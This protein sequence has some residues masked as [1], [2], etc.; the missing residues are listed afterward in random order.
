[1]A[2]VPAPPDPAATFDR[3]V[4]L[5][6]PVPCDLFFTSAPAS[7]VIDVAARDPRATTPVHGR[8]LEQVDPPVRIFRD[9]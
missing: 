8:A 4:A 5:C 3:L 7:P 6:D 1:M 9:R 2:D